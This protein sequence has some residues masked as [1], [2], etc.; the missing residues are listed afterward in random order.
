LV[1]ADANFPASKIVGKSAEEFAYRHVGETPIQSRTEG[2][3]T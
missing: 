3:P 2:E 1:V